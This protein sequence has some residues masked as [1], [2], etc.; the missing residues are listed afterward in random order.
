MNYEKLYHIMVDASERA[1][2]AIE[3]QNYGLAKEILIAAEQ[4]AETNA[5]ADVRLSLRA[6]SQTGAAIRFLFPSPARGCHCCKKSRAN[7]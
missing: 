7:E 6:G 1:I 4:K 5:A 3:A 2:E